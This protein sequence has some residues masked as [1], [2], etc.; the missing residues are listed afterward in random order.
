MNCDQDMKR[1][2]YTALF[3]LGSLS[4]CHQ[5]PERSF[6]IKGK[7]FPVCARCTG[8]FIGYVL[9]GLMYA[10]IQLPIWLA[11]LFCTIMFIDWLLQRID[12]LQSNN[13]RRLITGILCGGGLVQLYLR[14]IVLI[15]ELFR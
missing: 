13:M 1:Q 10:A 15:A 8:A 6:F 2:W 7:Q 4:G 9:G 5:L 11:V 14:L 12:V 3:A